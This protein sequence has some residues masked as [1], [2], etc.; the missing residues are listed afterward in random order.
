MALRRRLPI[1]SDSG[2]TL[3]PKRLFF[4]A[5]SYL[6]GNIGGQI[7]MIVSHNAFIDI[8]F[9]KYYSIESGLFAGP[10][11]QEDRLQE[12]RLQEDL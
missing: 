5:A 6:L 2:G 12:D 4:P 7:I 3:F 9:M 11:L 1:V 8:F 10:S